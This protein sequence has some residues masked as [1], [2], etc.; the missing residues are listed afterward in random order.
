MA[1]ND[2]GYQLIADPHRH[3]CWWP[4]RTSVSAECGF[5]FNCKSPAVGHQGEGA[6]VNEE[7][8]ETDYWPRESGEPCRLSANL[9]LSRPASRGYTEIYNVIGAIKYGRAGKVATWPCRPITRSTYRH[10][11]MLRVDLQTPSIISNLAITFALIR[12][13]DGCRD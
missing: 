8:T 12:P 9:H 2:S 7:S 4:P 13:S 10:S 6:N 5:G 11:C 1:I 3:L